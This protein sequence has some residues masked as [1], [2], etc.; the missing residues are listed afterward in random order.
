[1]E[2]NTYSPI[3]LAIQYDDRMDPEISCAHCV[4]EVLQHFNLSRS[5]SLRLTQW[6]QR[7]YMPDTID[8]YKEIP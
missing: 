6:L 8:G 5:A 2:K 1:M 3:E 7:R 4:L